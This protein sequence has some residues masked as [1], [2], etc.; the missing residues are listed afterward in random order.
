MSIVEVSVWISTNACAKNEQDL[1]IAQRAFGELG[2]VGKQA[3]LRYEKREH[4]P[5]TQYWVFVSSFVPTLFI[6]KAGN[7]HGPCVA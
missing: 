1:V 5:D 7:V 6:S 3:Q 4:H 2:G